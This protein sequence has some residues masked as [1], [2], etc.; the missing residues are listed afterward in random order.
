M[1]NLATLHPVLSPMLWTTV[2][3]GKRP[4]KHGILGFSEPTPRRWRAFNQSPISVSANQS[5]LEHPDSQNGLSSNVVGWWPSHPAEPIQGVMVS[6]HFQRATGP[7]EQPW[8]TPNWR[9]ASSLNSQK[10]SR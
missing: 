5:G 10:T 1:A 2:A 3:T 7:P 6:N 4:F 8:P 9:C